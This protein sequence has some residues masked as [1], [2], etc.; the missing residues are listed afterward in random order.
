MTL[1]LFY[2]SNCEEPGVV[3]IAEVTR[4]AYPDPYLLGCV[5]GVFRSD[6]DS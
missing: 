3:G 4:E 6:I 5:I 2:H 1:V